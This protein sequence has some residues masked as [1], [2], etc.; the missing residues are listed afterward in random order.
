MSNALIGNQN[1]FRENI[2]RFIEK[3]IKIFLQT[4]QSMENEGNVENEIYFGT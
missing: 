4:R 1:F 3:P 2:P